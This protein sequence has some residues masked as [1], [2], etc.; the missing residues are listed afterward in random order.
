MKKIK[1]NSCKIFKVLESCYLCIR[2]PFLYPRNRFSGLHYNNYKIQKILHGSPAQ[3]SIIKMEDGSYKSVEKIPKTS[4]LWDKAFET[5]KDEHIHIITKSRFYALL[6][7]VIEFYHNYILQIFHCIPTFTELDAMEPGW[8]KAFGIQMCKDIK[9][10]LKKE[11]FLYKYRITQIKEKFG[12]LRWYD[13]CS[14][15]EIQKIIQKYEDLSWNTCIICGKPSTKYT[16]G[17]ICPYCDE[18]APENAKDK[19]EI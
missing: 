18:H 14:S 6:Y 7:Y 13:E 15:E 9:K 8:R 5:I 1:W 19:K 17:W 11:H 16:T 3:R 2:F 12:T 4:G 10:Q